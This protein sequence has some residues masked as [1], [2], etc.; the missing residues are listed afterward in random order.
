MNILP[1]YLQA[2]RCVEQEFSQYPLTFEGAVPTDL[3]GTL[4]RNGNGR[5]EHQGITY[6]HLFDGDGMISAFEFKGGKVHYSNRYVRTDEFER[7]EAA[8]RMLYRSFGT[9]L[10]GGFSRN[11]LKMHFK[12]AAN[13]NVIFHGG[14][15]LALWEGGWPHRLEPATL[16]T[17]GRYDYGGVLRNDF[18]FIDRQITPELPFSAHPKVHPGS[19]E[20][21]NFGTA[22][23]R[24]QV[25]PEQTNA[26]NF[27][28]LKQ[29]AGKTPMVVVLDDGEKLRGVI[30]WYDRDCIK[31]NR[32]REPNMLVM[33]RH[34]KY[35]Y[36]ERERR[37]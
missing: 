8:G 22:A 25:P 30:E 24:K 31:V 11:F 6:D 4:F 21:F 3:H 32:I 20:L 28:Y 12:N 13:T 34:I 33:K 10:P 37:G 35:M 2:C 16:E 23:G 18:S 9:N 29:M 7:E 36:K 26:E 19:G 1:A 15:L 14:K 27:Y 5:F 17:L